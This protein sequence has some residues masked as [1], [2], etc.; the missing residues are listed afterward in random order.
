MHLSYVKKDCSQILN[1]L[2]KPFPALL[3]EGSLL[4]DFK[5]VFQFGACA[6]N[7][8]VYKPADQMPVDNS[9]KPSGQITNSMFETE[10]DI[11]CANPLISSVGISN[12]AN[13]RVTVGLKKGYYSAF[14]KL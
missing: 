11:F 1:C 3:S 4:L 6:C 12:S 7:S 14:T 9:N 10:F 8:T 13:F 5:L 2:R